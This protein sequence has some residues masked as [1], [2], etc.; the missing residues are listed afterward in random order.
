MDDSR[1]ASG[2]ADEIIDL[3][4]AGQWRTAS[5]GVSVIEPARRR[6]LG[7]RARPTTAPKGDKHAYRPGEETTACGIP[8]A[9]LHAWE[10]E[11]FGDGLLNRCP[12]C[13]RRTR[14]APS[15]VPWAD[16]TR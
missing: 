12:E 14:S 9:D 4:D 5:T 16:S 1:A 11:R 7:R 10:Q 2:D 8:V 13:L 6:G 3:T 15:E